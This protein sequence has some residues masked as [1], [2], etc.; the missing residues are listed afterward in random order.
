VWVLLVLVMGWLWRLFLWTRFL[1][2]VSRLKLRLVASHPD[3]A[4]GL[5]FAGISVQAFSIVAFALSTIVAGTIANRVMHNGTDILSFK[6]AVLAFVVFVVALF[7]SP[8]LIF[9]A[10]LLK[11]WRNG[12]FEYGALARNVGARMERKWLNHPA[13]D[14]ALDATDFSATTDLYAVACN[15]YSMGVVPLSLVNLLALATATVLP[16]LPVVAMAISPAV[17]LQKLAGVFL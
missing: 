8:L 4:G 17:M 16:F 15:V 9:M 10:P 5:K 7:A 3:R 6:Y 11:T 13:D 2:L 1:F 14:T 12:V